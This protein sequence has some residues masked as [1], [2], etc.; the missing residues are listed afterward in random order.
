MMLLKIKS[1]GAAKIQKYLGIPKV[2]YNK[3]ADL[4]NK[5]AIYESVI[6]GLTILVLGLSALDVF[7]VTSIAFTSFVEVFDLL[8]CGV[9]GL[10]LWKRY[11]N[12]S[13][14]ITTKAFIKKNGIEIF[15]IIPL[16][17][18]FRAFRLVRIFR[19][20]KIGG[21]AKLGRGGNLALKFFNKF[22]N[23]SYLRFK[24]FKTLIQAKGMK[25]P[26]DQ[27]DG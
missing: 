23:P 27:K 3:F 16:D 21:L 24:R 26:Q 13:E 19:L 5:E 4:S 6:I 12:K 15:A 22:A 9:F 1:L 20:A 2:L 18:A 8:V 17:V 7:L 11:K 25:D 14:E 10:D